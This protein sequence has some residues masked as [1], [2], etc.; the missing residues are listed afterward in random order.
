[1]N[2][3]NFF[4]SFV[5]INNVRSV[6]VIVT[7]YYYKLNYTLLIVS[8]VAGQNLIYILGTCFTG[9]FKN[10]LLKMIHCRF[11]QKRY[12]FYKKKYTYNMI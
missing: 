4:I 12:N 2:V 7:A 10:Y 3:T 5:F 8:N 1:M 6:T 9:N 11:I